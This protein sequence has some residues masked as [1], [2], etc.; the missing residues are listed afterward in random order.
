MF[1][2]DLDAYEWQRYYDDIDE[3]NEENGVICLPAPAVETLPTVPNTD[4][5]PLPF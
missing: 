1:H 5:D 3:Y 4:N 2:P